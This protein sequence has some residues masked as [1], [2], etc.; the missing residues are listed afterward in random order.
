MTSRV[1]LQF[2]LSRSLSSFKMTY[3]KNHRGRW[4]CMV[5]FFAMK[6][7]LFISSYRVCPAEIYCF[8]LF[9][10]FFNMEVPHADLTLPTWIMA[11]PGQHHFK[12][13][14][15]DFGLWRNICYCGDGPFQQERKISASWELQVQKVL[16]T[17]LHLCKCHIVQK[18]FGFSI[19][20][21]L[22]THLNKALSYPVHFWS[23]ACSEQW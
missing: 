21:S 19:L 7:R 15:W 3:L 20:K 18:C 2:T 23:L 22:K 14:H 8:F 13:F 16:K 6:M 1:S 12:N 9:V 17:Y 4:H 11:C 10:C 5:T